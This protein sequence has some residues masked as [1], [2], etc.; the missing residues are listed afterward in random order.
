MRRQVSPIRAFVTILPGNVDGTFGTPTDMTIPP[1]TAITTNAGE[2]S[3]I[4]VGD[5]NG[6]GKLDIVVIAGF[7][8]GVLLSNGDGTFLP[9]QFITPTYDTSQMP[10]EGSLALGDF[11]GDGKLDVATAEFGLITVFQGQGTGASSRRRHTMTARVR[12]T[13]HPTCW[14]RT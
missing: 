5:F 12:L 3:D 13:A 1:N 11:N 14:R 10:A 6:D 8:S 9:W 7:D 4:G 2:A